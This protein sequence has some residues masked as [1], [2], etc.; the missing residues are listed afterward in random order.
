[1]MKRGAVHVTKKP[2]LLGRKI[3]PARRE[4]AKG[5]GAAVIFL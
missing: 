2:I 3:M 5:Y 1:M 4:E